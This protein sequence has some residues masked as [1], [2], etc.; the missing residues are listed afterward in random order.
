MQ[1]NFRFL[2]VIDD[3]EPHVIQNWAVALTRYNNSAVTT[4]T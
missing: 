2:N 4:V 3:F 1:V